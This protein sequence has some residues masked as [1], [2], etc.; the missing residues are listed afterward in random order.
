[1]KGKRDI[2]VRE[3]E[4]KNTVTHKYR[5]ASGITLVALVV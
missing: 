2:K 3:D 1:M 4:P 5:T